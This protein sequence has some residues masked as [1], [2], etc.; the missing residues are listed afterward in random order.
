MDVL[1]Q[2]WAAG[3]Y[4]LNKIFFALA[5]GRPPKTKRSLKIWGWI[6]YILG[7]PGWVIIL[8]GHHNW[9]AASIETGGLPSMFL[10]LSTIYFN[11]KQPNKTLNLLAK[12]CVYIFLILGITYSLIDF[13]G[14][15]SIR[16]VLEI[17]AMA[18]F[19]IGSYLFAKENNKG[20]LCFMV[21]NF[22]MMVLLY[23]QGKPLLALQQVAS[24]C[25][26]GYGYIVSIKQN[27]KAAS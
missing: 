20:W 19:L 22:C 11:N 15:T 8:T 7:V 4:L 17:V 27:E 23:L 5:E 9:I 24:L 18:G 6:V 14:I 13:G 25:F 3:F 1:I 16:Q 12:A 21:M 2:I 10:G 26:V